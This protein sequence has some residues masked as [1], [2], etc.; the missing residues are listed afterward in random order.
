MEYPVKKSASLIFL[1]TLLSPHLLFPAPIFLDEVMNKETQ[2]E[3]GIYKLSKNQKLLLENWLNA[4][5]ELKTAK[6][7]TKSPLSVSLNLRSGK[8]L[9]LSDGSI[10]DIAPDDADQAALWISPV[11]IQIMTEPSADYPY[12]LVNTLSGLGVKA[13]RATA[14]LPPAPTPPPAPPSK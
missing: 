2:K 5:F 6:E 3:T 8:Q 13:R 4:N 14:L 7:E 10:W 9:Q 1:I 11:P 12:R